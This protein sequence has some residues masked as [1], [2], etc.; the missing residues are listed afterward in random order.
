M[1]APV[2][3]KGTGH[4]AA[5]GTNVSIPQIGM[6]ATVRNRRGVIASVNGFD[7]PEGRLHHVAVEYSDGEQPGE[8]V[9]IWEREPF[10]YLL[11]AGAL[12]NP[13]NSKPMDRE[14][15]LGMIRACRWQARTPYIDPDDGGP[16][17]RLPISAPFHGAV[18]VEDYQMVPLLKALNMPRVSLL[19]ADDVGVGK[20]VETGLIL[21]ELILRRRIR[22]VL[23]LTPA[24]LKLQWRD[25]MWD[26]FSLYFDTIDRDSTIRLRRQMGM[27]A[28]PWR[29]FS[30]IIA[31]YHYLKQADVLEQFRSA[32]QQE[33]LQAHL[34]W[35]LLIVDEAHNLTPSPFGD[36]SDLCK[37][38]RFIAPYFEH[39]IF[40]SA[41]PHNGHTR[42]FTGLLELLDPVRFS[43]TDELNAAARERVQQVVIRRLKRE[44]NERSD[45]PRFC[46]RLPPQS[47]GL[48]R[49]LEEQ[50]LSHAFGELKTGIRRVIASERK[51]KRLAGNFAIEILGKR[52][53][54]CPYAFA[55]SWQRCM[56]GMA[57]VEGV[58]DS[59][60]LSAQKSLAAETADD[61]EAASREGVLGSLPKITG[62]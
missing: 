53:L 18:Q 50:Q 32:S 51:Q 15:M 62:Q 35:D 1:S 4:G 58:E 39:K 11:P 52:L 24:S 47:L 6:V 16:M 20:T 2:G 26:K 14:D 43:Q 7:G 34:P 19:I 44:I 22:K 38:L 13:L 9:L 60:V 45:K 10:G 8:E 3:S 41:T 27:D 61:R 54:S 40:L 23:I 55:E 28:N 59:E 31:S 48:R 49:I 12:P 37:M 46:T 5:G 42:S 36:E 17:Q 57:E 21:T 25:E 29:S 56:Q 33:G 30:R